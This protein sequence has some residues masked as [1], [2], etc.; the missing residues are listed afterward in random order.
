MLEIKE[1]E[2]TDPF[3]PAPAPLL[4]YHMYL[5]N[6]KHQID[7]QVEADTFILKESVYHFYK[8]G[9]L[10]ACFPA[11]KTIIYLIEYRK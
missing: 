9:A 5:L 7:E 10:V 2:Y 8:R 1:Y 3:D 4:V 11:D 6:G